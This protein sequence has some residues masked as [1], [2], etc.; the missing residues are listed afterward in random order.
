MKKTQCMEE[1][2]T[3]EEPERPSSDVRGLPPI[4]EVGDILISSDLLTEAFCCDLDT[5][6]GACCIE[7]DAGAPVTMD[8]VMEIEN[9]VDAV[10]PDLSAS[11]Q[12]VIDRQGV[13]YVD[14]EGDLVT[15]I[16]GGKDCVFTCYGD[17]DLGEGH[18]VKNCCLCALE[19]AARKKTEA[20]AQFVKPISCALYPIREKVFS[21]GTVALNYHQWDICRCGRELGRRLHLPVYRFLKAPLIRRF[22]QAWYDELCAVADELHRQGYL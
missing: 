11:A 12:S 8:E 20:E 21:D 13:A 18:M 6:H 16:V 15:S 9:H 4:I 1:R 22:G 14:Q 19:R 3:A 10:W 5:C 2:N 7:G 17:I